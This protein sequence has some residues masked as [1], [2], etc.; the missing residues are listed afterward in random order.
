MAMG[1]MDWSTISLRRG[2]ILLCAVTCAVYANAIDNPFHYDDFHSIVDNG[3]LRS[4][5][6]V[7]KF[8]L[9]PTAFSAEPQNAMYRPLLLASFALNYAVS[10]YDTWSYHLLSLLLHL[11]C[12]GLVAAVGRALLGP[13]G[14]AW[15]AAC[16]F[17]IHPINS[18]PL[19]YIS[20][21]SEI[22][23]ALFFLLAFWSYLQEHWRVERWVVCIALAYACALLSKSIAIVLPAV[24]LVHALLFSP[25]R[26]ALP[27]LFAVL[28][29]VAL[30]YLAFVWTFLARATLGAPVR[31]YQ[32][33]VWT[34]VKALVFYLKMILWPSGQSIDHQ[35]LI[36]DS[37]FDPIA[38]AAFLLLLSLLAMALRY[39][40]GHPAPAFFLAWFLLVL[41][42][43]SLVPLNVLVNEHRLYLPGVAFFLALGYGLNRLVQYWPTWR[44]GI[45]AVALVIAVGM[46]VA[47]VQR[48]GLWSSPLALWQSAAARAPLMARPHIYWG[49][50]L[51]ARGQ[52]DQ[53]I[54]AYEHALRRDPAFAPLHRRLGSAYVA[55]DRPK[56]AIAIYARGVKLDAADGAMWL[57][58]GEALRMDGRWQESLSAYRRAVD[59][60]PD[61]SAAHNNLG[62][63]YQVLEQ[64]RQALAHHLRAR[65]L[66]PDD[67]Q[68]LLNLGNAY[69]MLSDGEKAIEA[70]A[71]AVE[72][73]P[74]YDGAW[75]NLA[76]ALERAGRI[77][78]ALEAYE[79]ALLLAAENRPYL[80]TKIAKLR[81]GI[82]E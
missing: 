61:D 28:A 27:A 1:R 69:A 60:L 71:K 12:V 10:G 11:G 46:A 3:R 53:A 68:T 30:S 42:P 34:Q 33:Q 66:T 19:N 73:D 63:T 38:A 31:S 74:K 79:R 8:F 51:E 62:N 58:F 80:Q 65:E 18:E 50:A 57:G 36:S 14:G 23:A 43:S 39:R 82:Y 35:F 6:E 41:A 47:T 54:Y 44:R 55:V 4:L 64:P 56:E 26:R 49:A 81:E 32:E 17:A 75:L 7:P 25:R 40:C 20:S 21:R 24:I 16:L 37:L 52:F 72:I 76:G 70:Y 59:L 77:G 48:N 13:S 45:E 67:A 22:M 29:G 5:A 9:D 15:W 2:W 78:Q